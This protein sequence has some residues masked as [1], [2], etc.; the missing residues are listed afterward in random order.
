[1]HRKLTVFLFTALAAASGQDITPGRPQPDRVTVSVDASKPSTPIPQTIFG[2]FLEPIG[3]AI[4]NGLWAEILRNPSFENGLWDGPHI[5][6][7]I[8]GDPQLARASNL[9]L[10]L[11]WEPLNAHQGNRY[12][13]RRGDAANSWQSLG[14]FGVPGQETGIRQQ[15][16]LPVHRELHYRG[17]I[18]VKHLSGAD[19]MSISIRKRNHDDQILATARFAAP[20][21]EWR[22]YSFTLDVPSAAL[23]PLE[24]ADFVV[25]VSGDERALVDQA[26]LMPAD[27]IGGLNPDMVSLAKAMHTSVLRFGGNFTSAYH[28]RDGIGPRDKRV[29]MRNI[30]WGI[31][32]Y[33]QFGTDEFL[34][35]CQLIGAQPQIALNL[36]SG[37]PAEAAA[38][39]RYV[40]RHWTRHSGLLW[41]LG[42]ELWG[43]WNLGYPTLQQLP[44]RTLAFSRAVHGVDP[45]AR[46]IATGA[47]PDHFQQWNDAQLSNPPGTFQFLS[48]HFVVGA[49]R[50]VAPNKNPEATDAAAFALP[51]GLERKLQEMQA[52]INRS[53]NFRNRAHIAFTEWLFT[54]CGNRPPDA[55]R[56]DDM[57]GAIDAAGFLNMLMRHS[58]IVPVSD[59]TGIVEFAGISER[60]GEVFAAPAYYAFRM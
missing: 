24:P 6:R 50:V 5:Q 45:S 60:R 32:E 17:S 18:F 15:I 37:T 4:D 26:S 11:P 9:G 36:G 13:P 57:G 51:V 58:A 35:F 43:N 39:V 34:H 59:M 56:F 10:P 52:Q 25:E 21:S 38:W 44:A 12:E 47:D 22:K 20:A 2:T 23:A 49:D 48:T 1:M 16:F 3:N 8:A 14:I 7:M 46:L 29:S 19:E 53:P 40:D 27:A 28:W 30:A 54:C 42:N 33:N 41:E 55:P 31:P